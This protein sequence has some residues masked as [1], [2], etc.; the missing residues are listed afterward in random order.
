MTML[1]HCSYGWG[2]YGRGRNA[3]DEPATWL[4]RFFYR[5]GGSE[6]F[7]EHLACDKH[8]DAIS[9][10]SDA[11]VERTRINPRTFTAKGERMYES[12]KAGY[13]GDPRTRDR[14]AEIAARTVYARAAEGVEG[15]VKRNKPEH[16]PRHRANP[17]ADDFDAVRFIG[18]ACI[19]LKLEDDDSYSGVIEVPNLGSSTGEMSKWAF[20]EIQPA[21]HDARTKSLDSEEM[22]D[23]IA[24]SAASFG[25]YYT[26]HNRGSGVPSWAPDAETADDIDQAV[27]GD[28]DDSGRYTVR[29]KAGSGATRN[30]STNVDALEEIMGAM[31][32]CGVSSA[33]H[34]EFQEWIAHLNRKGRLTSGDVAII[35]AARRVPR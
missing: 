28:M 6:P 17:D 1:Q 33:A 11:R 3:C 4:I 22:F 29:R 30:P 21:P 8:K 12:I 19:Y 32:E 24:Q 25:S 5:Y 31:S 18:D 34:V 16:N 23:K 9:S 2:R 10:G 27:S 35:L 20:S 15:L 14:A 7:E 26:S 13:A